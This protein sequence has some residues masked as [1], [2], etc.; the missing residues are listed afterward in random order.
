MTL[1]INAS[2]SDDM[3]TSSGLARGSGAAVWAASGAARGQEFPAG[4]TGPTHR[5][6]SI[7]NPASA[8][9]GQSGVNDGRCLVIKATTLILSAWMR[10]PA[11]DGVTAPSETSPDATAVAAGAPPR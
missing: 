9:V 2:R 6:A 1:R 8:S 11:E 5:P 7:P 4:A 10:P 3:P